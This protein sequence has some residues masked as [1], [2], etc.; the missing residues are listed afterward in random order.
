METQLNKSRGFKNH[1][2]ICTLQAIWQEVSCMFLSALF[3]NTVSLKI[4][5]GRQ[6][7]ILHWTVFTVGFLNS[8]LQFIL[9][10]DS[11]CFF[12]WKIFFLKLQYKMLTSKSATYE[13]KAYFRSFWSKW[14]YIILGLL[15]YIY[16]RQ[17]I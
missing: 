2:R 4:S 10:T 12:W 6:M 3:F 8:K 14:K 16:V 9:R 17:N 7:G 1:S 11:L 5:F 15:I 13:T